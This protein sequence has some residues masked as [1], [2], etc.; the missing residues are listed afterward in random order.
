VAD[1]DTPIRD[2]RV[3]QRLLHAIVIGEL[4]PGE[5]LV[6]E[7]LA[8]RLGETR[9]VIHTALIRLS[10]DGVVVRERNRGARV[11]RVSPREAIEVIE[12]RRAIESL[13]AGYAALRRT[14]ADVEELRRLVEEMDQL[15]AEGQL[16]ELSARNAI[17]HQ[18]IL[19]ISDHAVAAEVSRRLRPQVVRFQFRT[20]L[21][22]GRADRSFAE[23]RRLV[24]AIAD[25]DQ[26]V[27]EDA[28]YLHLT[29]VI[30]ALQEI[31][32]HEPL[33]A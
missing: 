20:V 17:L 13:A 11:R 5:R 23:H 22:P 31:A 3:Y 4:A 7:E 27:A 16:L 2:E 33:L 32:V 28:M 14:D 25:A 24:E 26:R 8:E 21:A 19:E 18:R 6:E 9:G 29:H 12:A 1:N 30:E 15:K 10:H